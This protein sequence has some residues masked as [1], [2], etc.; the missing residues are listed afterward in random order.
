MDGVVGSLLL[1]NSVAGGLA[2]PEDRGS[3]MS[4]CPGPGKFGVV[5]LPGRAV[6]GSPVGSGLGDVGSPGGA[7]DLLL[8]AFFTVTWYRPFAKYI[9]QLG[10]FRVRAM[11]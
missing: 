4:V 9:Y 1:A 3:G 7:P 5:G 2:R 8:M 10:N 11:K 6:A